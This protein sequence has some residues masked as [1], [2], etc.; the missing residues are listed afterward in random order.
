[1]NFSDFSNM[2]DYLNALRNQVENENK[3]MEENENLDYIDI[4]KE[5]FTDILE[6]YEMNNILN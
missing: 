6:N 4:F 5:N 3:S 1:M 2:S